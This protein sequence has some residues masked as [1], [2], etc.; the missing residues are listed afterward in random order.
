MGVSLRA[1]EESTS[2]GVTT[3]EHRWTQISFGAR[4]LPV[5]WTTGTPAAVR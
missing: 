1:T 2:L 3:D 4:P 5:Y